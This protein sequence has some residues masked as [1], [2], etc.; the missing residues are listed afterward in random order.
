MNYSDFIYWR[1]NSSV[2]TTII[3]NIQSVY[4]CDETA[5]YLAF[6]LKM[7]VPKHDWPVTGINF[8]HKINSMTSLSKTFSTTSLNRK[9][10]R[11][12]TIDQLFKPENGKEHRHRPA[13]P[14]VRHDFAPNVLES[15]E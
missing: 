11:N 3:R 12:T 13:I 7:K 8:Y 4:G 14:N 2:L 5:T 10:A 15:F 6:T 1:V 9:M